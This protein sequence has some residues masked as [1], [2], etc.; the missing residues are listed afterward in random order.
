MSKTRLIV[1]RVYQPIPLVVGNTISLDE[2]ASHHVGR[3]LRAKVNDRVALFN[4][5]GIEVEGV[6]HAISKKCVT[7]LITAL[8]P[9]SVE[10]PLHLHL[11]QGIARGEKMDVIV[12]KAVELGVSEITPLITERCNVRLSGERSDKR[13]AHWQA[14]AVSAAEQSGRQCV[15]TIHAPISFAAWLPPSMAETT[16]I[17]SPHAAHK[18]TTPSKGATTAVTVMVGPE[19]GFSEEEVALAVARGVQPLKL[20]PRILRTETAPIA[21]LSILQYCLGDMR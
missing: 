15:P 8:N 14:V 12:Q 6:I 13:W 16:F 2:H 18:L 11:V 5:V 10:S 7:V 4:D 1:A 9:V 17:L 19:G 20:G 3:V 21:A